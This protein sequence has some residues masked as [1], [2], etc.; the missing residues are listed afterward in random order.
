M[1]ETEYSL[2]MTRNPNAGDSKPAELGGPG[3]KRKGGADGGNW[4]ETEGGSK[5]QHQSD[6]PWPGIQIQIHV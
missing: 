1:M 6:V 5:H 2:K 3:G 4:G